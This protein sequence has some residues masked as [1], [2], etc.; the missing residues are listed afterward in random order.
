MSSQIRVF[1]LMNH[2]SQIT[3]YISFFWFWCFNAFNFLQ[4]NE[5]KY[6]SFQGT[7]AFIEITCY[8]LRTQ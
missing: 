1:H 4:I 2:N 3:L 6:A 8:C 7:R 5:Q